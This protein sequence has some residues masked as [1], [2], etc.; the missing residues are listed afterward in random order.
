GSPQL[1][2]AH[3]LG[4]RGAAAARERGEPDDAPRRPRAE[5]A[6]DGVG[7]HASPRRA[8]AVGLRRE[9]EMRVG[10]PRLVREADPGGT[11]QAEGGGRDAPRR[12]RGA[13]HRALL[14][15][16]ARAADG[17]PLAAAA[18]ARAPR[19]LYRRL[20]TR[21]RPVYWKPRYATRSMRERAWAKGA[22]PKA[23]RPSRWT[24]LLRRLGLG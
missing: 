13:L 15:R 16:G 11:P 19:T 23:E 12:D 9:G 21:P 4:L 5:R 2:R 18:H 20:V 10:R 1:A 14:G 17:A 6:P 3:A 24:R 22:L 8:R 7:H